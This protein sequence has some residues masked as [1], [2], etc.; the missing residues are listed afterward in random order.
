MTDINKIKK[1]IDEADA[2]IIGA[3]AGLSDAAGIHYS[4]EKF[5]EDFK[6]F[7]KK[8]GFKDLYT[9]SFY[10]FKTEEERWAY[11][12]KHIYFSYYERKNTDLYRKLYNI[13]K[14]KNYFVITTNTDGQFINN[15]FK[16]NKIFE[17][18]GSYSKL[19]CITPCHNKLYDNEKTIKKLL[20]NID[21]NLKVSSSLVPK[22][23][24]CHENMSVNLRCDDTFVEDNHWHKMEKD[25]NDFIL[26]SSDKKVLLLEFGV[27][28]NTP[29]IIRFPFEEMT[30]M[31]DNF[32]LIRF[33]DNYS[34]VPNEIKA[35]S[36]SVSDS[37]SEVIDLLEKLCR[38]KNE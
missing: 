30:F 18:Q 21:E 38:G 28:F 9:S 1:W 10:Q 6:D 8:Y 32:R 23:P 31:H 2:I 25:Y 26:N 33:N 5:E 22:C 29:S 14:D 7:I 36:I 17:V 20:Q 3:G 19:Q 15:G 35:K 34:L 13:V 16:K 12:A 27:G 37:I 11:W 4:G 24:V